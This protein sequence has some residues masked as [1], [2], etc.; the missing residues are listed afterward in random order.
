MVSIRGVQNHDILPV[1]RLAHQ[2]LPERYHPAIFNQ[3][4]ETFPEGFLVAHQNHT[5]IGFLVGVKTTPQTAR[6]LMLAVDPAHRKQGIGSA[7]L[8]AF[9]HTVHTQHVVR[10]ELE[11]RTTNQ[12]A[13]QFYL[14]HGFVITETLPQFY[15]NGQDAYCMSTQL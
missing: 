7:L 1:T 15:Q 6:I 5:T 13:I 9:L 11:V 10:V 3:F 2:L 4:Y 14:K 12:G 8:S